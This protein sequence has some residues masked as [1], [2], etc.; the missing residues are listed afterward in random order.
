MRKFYTESKYKRRNK[1]HAEL[2]LKR[3]VLFKKYKKN[4]N[5]IEQGLNHERLAHKR[6]FDDKFKGYKKIKAPTILSFI[7]NPEEVIDFI[8]NLKYYFEDK[9]KVFVVLKDVKKINYDAIVVLL[10]IMV[11]FKAHGIDF[12]GDFPYDRAA[13]KILR[14]SG[15]FQ[16][17]FKQFEDKDRYEL[18]K[19]N[20]IH[21]HAWKNVDPTLG[22]SIIKQASKAIWGEERRCQGVQRALIEL[23]LNTNNHADIAKEGEKH[24]W[25]SLNNRKEEKMSCFSFVDFGVGIFESLNNKK[26]GSKFFG[27]AEKL[28][29]RAKHGNNAE[30]LKLILN[31]DLHETVTGKH[32]RGKGLPGINEAMKRNQISN[33]YIITNDVYGDIANNSYRMLKNSFSGTFLYWELN[34]ANVSSYGTK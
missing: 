13:N 26:E 10:S 31:G 14:E 33:L 17:L 34:S 19:Q 8:N 2:S 25:L 9:K 16:N 15:F 23:M 5:I 12:N 21:T 28:I 1:K 20:N 27:W 3:Q 4:K 11:K 22:D 32:Y 24:W 6:K 29:K 30:L 7:D 18:G